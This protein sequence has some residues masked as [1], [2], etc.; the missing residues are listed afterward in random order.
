MA[1]ILNNQETLNFA[2][3]LLR[4]GINSN[5]HLGFLLFDEGIDTLQALTLLPRKE[6]W[7]TVGRSSSRAVGAFTFGGARANS[8]AA[9]REWGLEMGRAQYDIATL[10]AANFTDADR[11]IYA[12]RA[13]EE[14]DKSEMKLPAKFTD[15]SWVAFSIG[16]LQYLRALLGVN[17]I[18]LAYITRDD[19]RAPL[20]ANM[21][22]EE[23]KF[24]LTP[25]H[26]SFFEQDNN[27]AWTILAQCTM[28]TTAW[29]FIQQFRNT[30]N[31]RAAWRIL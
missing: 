31:G 13:V 11:M 27:R 21:N 1:A 9:L 25:L 6:L 28:Q 8:L 2:G 15:N 7:K 10:V 19:R 29:A 17:G 30:R 5:Q 20:R 3:L 12:R 24:W 4:I 26:G 16:I 14:Q 22:L 23:R 18:V